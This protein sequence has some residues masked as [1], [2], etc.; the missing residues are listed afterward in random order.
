MLATENA[1]VRDEIVVEKF[2]SMRCNIGHS[3]LAASSVGPI[4]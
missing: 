3:F 1:A 2:V 4:R